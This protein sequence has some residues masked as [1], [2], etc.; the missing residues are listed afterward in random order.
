[1]RWYW[2]KVVLESW[3]TVLAVTVPLDKYV[4]DNDDHYS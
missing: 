3:Q 4:W 2:K 1:M